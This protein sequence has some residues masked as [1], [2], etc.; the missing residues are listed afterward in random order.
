MVEF[1]GQISKNKG[2]YL[3]LFQLFFQDACLLAFKRVITDGKEEDAAGVISSEEVAHT[4]E[5]IR[6]CDLILGVHLFL[7]PVAAQEEERKDEDNSKEDGE[8]E[9]ELRVGVFFGS[10]GSYV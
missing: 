6:V 8:C 3:T 4:E 5:K 10:D 1:L 2:F 9:D 7:P